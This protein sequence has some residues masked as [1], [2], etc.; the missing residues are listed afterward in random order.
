MSLVHLPP[1][2]RLA[3]YGQTLS[4]LVA[5][6]ERDGVILTVERRPRADTPL[7]MGNHTAHVE[8]YASAALRRAIEEA[9]RPRLVMQ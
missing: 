7:A 1:D 2:Q 6:A 9:N 3:A 5:Q 4:L 8:A